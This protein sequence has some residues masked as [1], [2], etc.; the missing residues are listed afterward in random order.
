MKCND[1]VSSS[2]LFSF[3]FVEDEIAS[4]ELN[5]IVVVLKCPVCISSLSDRNR[6]W[7]LNYGATKQNIRSEFRVQQFERLT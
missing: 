2:L 5:Q 3:F 6:V 1:S 4:F 7:L